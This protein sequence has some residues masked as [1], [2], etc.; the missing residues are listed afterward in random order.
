MP[1]QPSSGGRPVSPDVS[2]TRRSNR[3]MPV[4][5]TNI[6]VAASRA[7]RFPALMARIVQSQPVT[8]SAPM[9]DT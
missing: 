1:I 3:A 2:L 8:P 6:V 9:M 5:S 4:P 7:H